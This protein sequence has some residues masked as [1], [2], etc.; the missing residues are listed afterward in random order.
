MRDSF[1]ARLEQLAAEDPR[2]LLITGDLGFGVLDKFEKRFPR[3]YLNAGVAEQNMTGLATGI[4]ME[5]RIVFTYSIGNFP[6]LRCLEQIRNDA[7]YHN[8]D[9]KVVAIG[10]GFSYGPLGMSHHATE[11][12]AI[13]RAIGIP[14]VAPGCDWESAEAVDAL[15]K[16][17]GTCYLRLDRASAGRTS[18]PGEEFTLGRAREL[19]SGDDVTLIATGGILAEALAA[20]D[21]LRANSGLKC[22]VLS[23]HTVNPLDVDAVLNAARETGGIVTVEEH[24][25]RGGL[26]GAVAE[27]CLDNGVSPRGFM[28]LGLRGGFTSIVGSQDYLR[29][30]YGL[31]RGSISAAVE[32]VARQS[33]GSGSA[34]LLTIDI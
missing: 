33:T 31:D 27:A 22:R 9:V 12:L 16:T 10:G 32:S 26:G 2:I 24:T 4:A 23:M 15:V 20:A 17:P 5:G 29:R 25:I 13:M 18:R 6:T 3:Q 7:A 21:D 8:A 28:R 11:D 14:V 34:R 19:R 30:L 1:T